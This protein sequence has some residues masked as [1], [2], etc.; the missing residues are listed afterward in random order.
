MQYVDWPELEPQRKPLVPHKM[1]SGALPGA[2]E[3]R[4]GGSQ[5]I[6]ISGRGR[7]ITITTD[8]GSI[9]FG[10]KEDGGLALEVIN[11]D[12]TRTGIGIVPGGTELGFYTTDEDGNVVQ[13]IV[14]PLLSV[15]NVAT[16]D[17]V[18]QVGK[19]TNGEYGAAFAK[20]GED[21]V[22]GLGS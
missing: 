21:L 15:F 22:D 4:I 14:G 10:Q 11:E 13:K 19:L 8:D 7:N 5:N 2:T 1:I 20:D 18:V 9:T 16:E 6:K 17:N 12:G 3:I